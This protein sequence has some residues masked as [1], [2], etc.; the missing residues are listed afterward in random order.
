MPN[1]R[2]ASRALPRLREAIATTSQ[3]SPRCMAGITFASP[4]LAVL[5]M[6][7]RT[8]SITCVPPC[9]KYIALQYTAAEQN[10]PHGL[11]CRH[12]CY[13]R[14]VGRARARGAGTYISM[15]VDMARDSYRHVGQHI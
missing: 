15:L 14:R 11:A 5:K 2:A 7:Q 8:L 9:E 1:R 6:P 10:V 13:N 12:N 3:Y 4:M